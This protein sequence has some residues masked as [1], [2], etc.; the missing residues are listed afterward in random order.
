MVSVHEKK[1]PEISQEPDEP[2]FVGK[3]RARLHKRHTEEGDGTGK[4]LN[5]TAMMDV[6]TILVVFLLKSYSTSPGA[7]LRD[8]LNPPASS[9][10]IDLVDAVTVSVTRNDVT[11]DDTRVIGLEDGRVRESD[12]NDPQRPLLIPALQ[13]ALTQEV[14]RLTALER[15][16]GP[17]FDGR[18]L[19][20]GDRSIDYELLTMIL[21]SAGQAGLSQFKFVTLAN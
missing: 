1:R 10:Q 15:A 8:G 16:G 5:L 9:T 7:D 12:L 20:V 17:E 11:V 4:E 19:L 18:M 21:Y 2:G 14:E 3:R 6:L 13:S